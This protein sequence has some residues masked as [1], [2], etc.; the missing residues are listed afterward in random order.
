MNHDIELICIV[1]SIYT[2]ADIHQW[3]KEE[4]KRIQKIVTLNEIFCFQAE[5]EF[6]GLSV[7]ETIGEGDVLVSA[8]PYTYK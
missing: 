3:V 8:E 7:M 4:W 6:L 2:C 1:V 5:H